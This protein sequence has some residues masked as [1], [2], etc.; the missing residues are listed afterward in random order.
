VR[1]LL[2]EFSRDYLRDHFRS[3]PASINTGRR[4]CQHSCL[5]TKP[6]SGDKPCTG[7]RRPFAMRESGILGQALAD[8]GVCAQ[9]EGS[10]SRMRSPTDRIAVALAFDT[11]VAVD[12][13]VG[14][15]VDTAVDTVDSVGIPAEDSSC[16]VGRNPGA[17]ATVA[18]E[19]LGTAAAFADPEEHTAGASDRPLA[20][21]GALPV[22]GDS[23]SPPAAV[24][25]EG[26][27][28]LA[29]AVSRLDSKD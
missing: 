4:F 15:A 11:V 14:T 24:A 22:A 25:A 17:S 19:R 1:R 20:E 8:K 26:P 29:E 9:S 10:L 23:N 18:P 7:E 27:F 6:K 3:K 2:R 21:P 12:T 5:K 28:G 16:F 13:A